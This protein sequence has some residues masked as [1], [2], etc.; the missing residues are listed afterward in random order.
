MNFHKWELFSGSP[1]TYVDFLLSNPRLVFASK[2]NC[3]Y[4]LSTEYFVT[5]AT[6]SLHVQKNAKTL[7][8]IQVIIPA[9]TKTVEKCVYEIGMG[10]LAP[11]TASLQIAL[12]MG[13]IHAATQEIKFAFQTTMALIVKNIACQQIAT[14]DITFVTIMAPKCAGTNGMV[15]IA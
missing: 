7:M 8:T 13:T 3:L 5:L 14:W 11:S 1:G 4:H 10:L 2:L 9:I 12:S 15:M 6:S